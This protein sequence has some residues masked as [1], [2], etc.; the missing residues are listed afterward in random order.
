MKISTL[1]VF[2]LALLGIAA[3]AADFTGTWK[4]EAHTNEGGAFPITVTLK[5]DGE[6]LTGTVAQGKSEPKEIENGKATPDQISFVL[7]YKIPAGT[8]TVTYTGKFE[9]DQLKLSSQREGSKRIQ[10]SML[11]RS[12]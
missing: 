8:R 2:G 9:G 7:T 5:V 12:N 3:F 1:I 11:T 10:D 4:G 6:N